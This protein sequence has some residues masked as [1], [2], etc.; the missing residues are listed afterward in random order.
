[1]IK[2]WHKK[3]KGNN[4]KSQYNSNSD[5]TAIRNV[6]KIYPAPH[7][8]ISIQ[9]APDVFDKRTNCCFINYLE[10]FFSFFLKKINYKLQLY[11]RNHFLAFLN[12]NY[13]FQQNI[14]K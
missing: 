8:R 10:H 1:M 14:I 7:A 4:S 6:K 2:W 5:A 11:E 13:Y 3:K 9:D 12:G